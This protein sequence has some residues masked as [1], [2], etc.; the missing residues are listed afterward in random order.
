MIVGALFFGESV[1]ASTLAGIG[2]IACGVGVLAVGQ[3]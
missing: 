2:T 3:G 1:N